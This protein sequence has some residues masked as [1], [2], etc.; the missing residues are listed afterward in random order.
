MSKRNRQKRE[1]NTVWHNYTSKLL[2][3]LRTDE[4]GSIMLEESHMLGLIASSQS[5]EQHLERLNRYIHWFVVAPT[6]ADLLK[7]YNEDKDDALELWFAKLQ[8]SGIKRQTDQREEIEADFKEMGR[9]APPFVFGLSS[10][11]S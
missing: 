7:I 5:P 8:P 11:R 4:A 9:P 6:E 2:Q 10:R 1:V 3:L